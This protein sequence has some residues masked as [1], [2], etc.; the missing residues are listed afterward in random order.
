MKLK[1]TIILYTLIS[2]IDIVVFKD[3]VQSNDAF[4]YLFISEKY[5]LGQYYEAISGYWSPLVSWLSIPFVLWIK[6]PVLIIKVYNKIAGLIALWVFNQILNS[7]SRN[8]NTL[9]FF[10]TITFIFLLSVYSHTETPDFISANLLF[11][12]VAALIFNFSNKLKSPYVVGLILGISYYAKLYNFVFSQ[13]LILATLFCLIYFKKETFQ[14]AIKFYFK[15]LAVY[16]PLCFVWIF[17]MHQKLGKWRYEYSSEFNMAIFGPDNCKIEELEKNMVNPAAKFGI[18]IPE[19]NQIYVGADEPR[20]YNLIPKWNMLSKEHIYRSFKIVIKNIKSVYYDFLLRYLLFPVLILLLFYKKNKLPIIN[21]Y[22]LLLVT[23]IIYV[24]GYLIIFY[25][26]RYAYFLHFCVFASFTLILIDHLKI[27]VNKIWITSIAVFAFLLLYRNIII[28]FNNDF[29]RIKTH[30]QLHQKAN[31]LKK[32]NLRGKTCLVADIDVE[33][34][35][36]LDE[37]QFDFIFI[38]YFLKNPICGVLDTKNVNEIEINKLNKD[39][40]NYLFA[41]EKESA[42]KLKNLGYKNQLEINKNGLTV[43]YK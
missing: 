11:L 22:S 32:L 41:Y 13:L 9:R 17:A 20:I 38:N 14:S 36:A 29:S 34:A 2:I 31:L 25:I 26:P 33:K 5:A 23:G 7:Q 28:L 27:N 43:Y 1:H 15:Q 12:A 40:I 21:I 24:S 10:S 39:S 4:P 3:F 16:L 42:E 30:Q 8:N 6:N 19:K 18:L 35:K 37:E